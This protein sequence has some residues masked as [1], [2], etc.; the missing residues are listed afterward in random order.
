[1]H[2]IG[3]D[4]M[5]YLPQNISFTNAISYTNNQSFICGNTCLDKFEKYL[6]GNQHTD[7]CSLWG[8][9][10]PLFSWLTVPFEGMSDYIL[11]CWVVARLGYVPWL[12]RQE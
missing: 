9:E 10:L 7:D 8:K 2:K 4:I 12:P 3:I 5:H 1:M 6:Y 11:R